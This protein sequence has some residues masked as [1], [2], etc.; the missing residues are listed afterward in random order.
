[1][2]RR[3]ERPSASEISVTLSRFGRNRRLVLRFEWLTR[4]PIWRVLPVNSQ[5]QAMAVILKKTPCFQR[6]LTTMWDL[7]G[8][9][10][11]GCP[12]RQ[13]GVKRLRQTTETTYSPTRQCAGSWLV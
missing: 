13:A 11:E 5:R 6:R 3:N 2:R 8:T 4:C 1:M 10:S 9:Y 7:T 12:E